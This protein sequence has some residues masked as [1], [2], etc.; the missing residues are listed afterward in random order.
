MIQQ[1]TPGDVA[2]NW[3]LIYDG[4]RRSLPPTVL[5]RE[6]VVNNICAALST[7]LMQAW[8]GGVDREGQKPLACLVAITAINTHTVTGDRSLEVFSLFNIDRAM[9]KVPD[10]VYTEIL[11][12]LLGF[13][14]EQRCG[15]IVGYTDQEMLCDFMESV[16]GEARYVFVR[17]EVLKDERTQRENISAVAG[18]TRQG[19]STLDAD[20]GQR[21]HPCGGEAQE[22]QLPAGDPAEICG[23]VREEAATRIG[24]DG[25]GGQP[26][27]QPEG[28]S[29]A[30]GGDDVQPD[31]EPVA[32]GAGRGSQP[33]AAG[34]A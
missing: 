7:G 8:M 18:R 23:L 4:I 14:R 12:R 2:T 25:G 11:E 9:V 16:G 32:A 24:Q 3:A 21:V 30:P 1:M 22:V 29:R 10:Q 6:G 17:L 13:A 31:S 34:L 27:G 28:Q 5:E 33:D 20:P 19:V 15:Q 26:A